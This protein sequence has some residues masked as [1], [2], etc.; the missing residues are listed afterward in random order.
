MYS[1]PQYCPHLSPVETIFG[2]LKAKMRQLRANES[3][4]FTSNRGRNSIFEASK[5]LDNL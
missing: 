1:I 2:I 3:I 4:C 5:E